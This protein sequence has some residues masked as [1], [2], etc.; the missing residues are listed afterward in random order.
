MKRKKS[1]ANKNRQKICVNAIP[2]QLQRF[3]ATA[4]NCSNCSE[5]FS[6]IRK[7]QGIFGLENLMANRPITSMYVLCTECRDKFYTLGDVAI[8]NVLGDALLAA[9]TLT[10]P[11]GGEA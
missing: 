7:K 10:A 4:T 8:A 3:I 2:F 9:H 1:P 6:A 5:P 11:V